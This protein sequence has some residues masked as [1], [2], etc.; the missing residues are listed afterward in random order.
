MRP[1]IDLN[2]TGV[3][4]SSLDESAQAALRPL[5]EAGVLVTYIEET[6]G[7]VQL[8]FAGGSVPCESRRLREFIRV[9]AAFLAWR[10]RLH[11]RASLWRLGGQPAELLLPEEETRVA[12]RWKS[13]RQP[14]LSAVEMSLIDESLKSQQAFSSITRNTAKPSLPPAV[15][16]P[17]EFSELLR[18]R[19]PVVQQAEAASA[20]SAAK[21]GT[22]GEFTVVLQPAPVPQTAEA[23][24]VAP[25]PRSGTT[26]EFTRV[27]SAP[28][29][30]SAP[31]AS[32]V[33]APSEYPPPVS[34]PPTGDGEAAQ[35]EATRLPPPRKIPEKLWL[36]AA[37]GMLL[38]FVAVAWLVSLWQ[39]QVESPPPVAA[40]QAPE[41]RARAAVAQN[42]FGEA[43][44][45][46]TDLIKAGKPLLAERAYAHRLAGDLTKAIADYDAAIESGI[47]DDQIF[48]DA[49]YTFNLMQ[50]P[51]QSIGYLTK[52][53]HRSPSNPKLYVDRANGY[54]TTK[55]YRPALADFENA[56]RIDPTSAAAQA[57]RVS[58]LKAL[59]LP[60]GGDDV[61]PRVYIQITSEVQRG[62]ARRLQ[63]TLKD[64]G[65]QIPGIEFIQR[66]NLKQNELRYVFPQDRAQAERLAVD[67]R[68][69]GVELVVVQ[70]KGNAARQKHFEIW[71]APPGET[72]GKKQPPQQYQRAL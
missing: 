57:G 19:Q 67:L 20:T 43:V 1:E 16:S 71:F 37:A 39:A 18:S 12:L 27:F 52:G 30:P 65:Y 42:R 33:T 59:K 4:W 49:A 60:V 15:P 22:T 21:T 34:A 51:E 5:I 72:D 31:A 69:S 29:S 41:N 47:A 10:Q 62:L 26:G 44:E 25:A 24:P 64:Q 36:A 61:P 70:V 66:A 56:L 6:S 9:N 11:A 14:E 2:V 46:Y 68:K 32:S 13:E 45:L 53:I 50:K 35:P 7:T 23:P 55:N 48:S 38:V 63:D 40:T 58:A 3:S 54:M 17:A 28:T 8:T